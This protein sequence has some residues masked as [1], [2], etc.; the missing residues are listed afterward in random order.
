MNACYNKKLGFSSNNRIYEGRF[1]EVRRT[2]NALQKLL[3]S[4]LSFLFVLAQPSTRAKVGRV[5]KAILV[6]ASLVGLVIVVGAVESDTLGLGAGF[7]I[8]CALLTVEFFCLRPKK[9][10][11]G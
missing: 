2:P 10:K 9:I 8:A 6:C 3:C 1:T 7:G 11:Q 4:L 5:A